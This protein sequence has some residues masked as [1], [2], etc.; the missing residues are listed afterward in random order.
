MT[1]EQRIIDYIEKHGSITPWEAAVDLHILRLSARVYDMKAR[2]V[3]IVTTIRQNDGVR[4]AEY[5][6]KKDPLGATNA[7]QVKGEEVESPL[8][9]ENNTNLYGGQYS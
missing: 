3:P 5:T 7:E 4:W 8:P 9:S 1:Q 6:I 2:G